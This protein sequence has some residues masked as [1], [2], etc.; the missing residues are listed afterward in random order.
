MAD[1]AKRRGGSLGFVLGSAVA[2]PAT[3]FALSN[4]ESTD[5]EFLGWQ[6]QVP[7]WVVIA[8]SLAAGAVIGVGLVLAWQARRRLGR[9]REAKAAAK[10]DK[11]ALERGS[12]QADEPSATDPGRSVDQSH[13]V[14][15]IEPGASTAESG[16]DTQPSRPST[17]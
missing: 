1:A 14:P 15:E 8:L 2:I 11:Q 12:Q 4:L 17:R 6:A 5:V 13:P 7:L 9:R 10:A 16:S 3:I